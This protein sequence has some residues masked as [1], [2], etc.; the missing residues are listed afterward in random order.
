MMKAGALVAAG[1][2]GSSGYYEGNGKIPHN[3]QDFSVWKGIG[4]YLCCRNSHS[5]INGSL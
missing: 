2:E 5:I 4:S 3:V 1:C